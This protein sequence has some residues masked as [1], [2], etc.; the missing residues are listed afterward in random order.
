MN[1]RL[2]FF[3]IKIQGLERHLL[4]QDILKRFVPAH[5]LFMES[6][7]FLRKHFLETLNKKGFEYEE[8]DIH[9]ILTIP[10]IWSDVAKQIMRD[11]ACMVKKFNS[12]R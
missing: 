6:I 3:L 7:R 8:D 4:V 12:F 10:A 5:G 1:L 2:H 9:Y 11:S